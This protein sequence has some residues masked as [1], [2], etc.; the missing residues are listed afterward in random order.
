MHMHHRTGPI[1]PSGQQV[2][3]VQFPGRVRA[4]RDL[5]MAVDQ[6]DFD[7]VFRV[8]DRLPPA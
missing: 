5:Q 1:H 7:H 2:M 4:G 6:F 8:D 3:H